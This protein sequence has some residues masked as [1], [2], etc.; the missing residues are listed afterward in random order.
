[1]E[2][3]QNSN[4]N[5]VKVMIHVNGALNGS[6]ETLLSCFVFFQMI[7]ECFSDLK[8]SPVDS[9]VWRLATVTV[10]TMKHLNGIEGVA[11]LWHEIVLELRFRWE[12]GFTI[13]G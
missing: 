9:L 12:N 7:Q 5:V 10:Y 11:H 3:M 13:P 1:M 8:S 6:H 4:K 2:G